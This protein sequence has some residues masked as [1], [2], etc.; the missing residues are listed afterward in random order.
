MRVLDWGDLMVIEL[1]CENCGNGP[2]SQIGRMN[3]PVSM[4][5]RKGEMVER[6]LVPGRD[7]VMMLCQ[8]CGFVSL[9]DYSTL[10]RQG[11]LPK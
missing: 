8:R 4:P 1:N 11:K 6:R 2:M 3:L 10:E 9:F 5:D 7:V